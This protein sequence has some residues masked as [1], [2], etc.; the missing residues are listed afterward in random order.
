M[1]VEWPRARSA[2]ARGGAHDDATEP[3]PMRLPDQ[4]FARIRQ[5][6]NCAETPV[7]ERAATGDAAPP[8]DRPGRREPRWRVDVAVPCARYA[9]VTHALRNVRLR[10]ISAVGVCVLSELQLNTG[11]RFIL[12]LP[13]GDGRHVAL[14]CTTQTCRISSDGMFRIGA[15]F[16]DPGDA[17]L[18]RRGKTRSATAMTAEGGA[19]LWTRVSSDPDPLVANAVGAGGAAA[20]RSER[21]PARGQATIYT[22]HDDDRRGPFEQ[23]EVRD[24]SPG[25]LAI[26]RAEPMEVGDRFVVHITPVGTPGAGGRVAVTADDSQ[27]TRL[28]RVVNVTLTDNKY[29]IGAEF[30]T[31][32]Q[33]QAQDNPAGSG[34]FGQRVRRWLR[35]TG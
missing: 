10:D 21:T 8:A 12:Y 16:T 22:Y 6:L 1:L 34:G 33:S 15:N 20:R 19:E 17:A 29:R 27:P 24:V 2:C 25:G 14:V 9:T 23:V 5:H 26:L 3:F 4:A 32:A 31:Q 30:I 28:A 13:D 35:K 11:E 18:R 7:D